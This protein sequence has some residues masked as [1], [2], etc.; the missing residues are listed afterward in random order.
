M[1]ETKVVEPGGHE[2]L[3]RHDVYLTGTLLKLQVG[4]LHMVSNTIKHLTCGR[5]DDIL[6]RSHD[7]PN[8]VGEEVNRRDIPCK[9]KF[10]QNMSFKQLI[11][12]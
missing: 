2:R 11:P 8:C 1:T 7:W 12:L 4:H 9:W 3:H 5:Q 6:S 10:N